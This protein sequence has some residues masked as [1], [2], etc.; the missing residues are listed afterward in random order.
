MTDT[1]GSNTAATE[2]WDGHNAI[3][4]S[5][6]DDRSAYK[7]LTSHERADDQYERSSLESAYG[8][9][10][11]RSHPRRPPRRSPASGANG[12]SVVALTTMPSAKPR[13]APIQMAA[14]ERIGASLR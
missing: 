14:P 13:T 8:R 4:V 2:G 10:R 1:T 11:C 12:T 6:E 5:F 3:A 7:A 9:R